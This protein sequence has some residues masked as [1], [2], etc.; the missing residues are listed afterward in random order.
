M[1]ETLAA[2][3]TSYPCTITNNAG[4]DVVVLDAFTTDTTT[5]NPQQM[6]EQTLKLLKNGTDD[7]IKAGATGTVALND[8][9]VDKNGATQPNLIYGFLLA[10][11]GSFF[12]VKAASTAS[13]ASPPSFPPV[14]VAAD[15][16]KNMALGEQFWQTI[17]AYPTSDMA[18]NFT[19][20]VSSA[21]STS[22]TASQVDTSVQNFFKNN[23]KDYTTLT[24]K[25][26]VA[27][28][29]YYNTYP[30]V[31]ADYKGSKTYYLYTSD[32]TTTTY[33]GSVVMNLPAAASTDKSLPDG[34]VMFT[35]ASGAQKKLHFK[36][37]QFVDDVTKDIPAVCLKGLFTLKSTLTK[38]DTDNVIIA[39][40]SGKANGKTV[41]GYPD[42]LAP[43]PTDPNDRWWGLYPLLH[44]KNGQDWLNLLGQVLM[45]YMAY[46]T[47][48]KKTNKTED[49]L[50]N[51]KAENNGRE[52]S[53]AQVDQ[54]R[55]DCNAAQ[56]E[57]NDNCQKLLDKFDAQLKMTD[58]L[59]AQIQDLQQKIEDRFNEEQRTTMEENLH[60]QGDE[61]TDMAQGGV[62]Q[63][64]ENIG[65][66]I[67]TDLNELNVDNTPTSGLTDI[68]PGIQADVMQNDTDL[69]SEMKTA[70]EN[71]TDDIKGEIGRIQDEVKTVED[72]A[73]SI[74]KS[75]GEAREGRT[76][77]DVK[78]DTKIE[79]EL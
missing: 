1:S 63:G 4:V 54:I 45:I 28:Q 16:A 66:T 69:T 65:G 7:A 10:R 32:G 37:G 47:I 20:A 50:A 75:A 53:Q 67:A 58:D 78:Y 52:P 64:M 14:I 43:Q 3:D 17:M 18:K 72:E 11:P 34:A 23:T 39:I 15:D 6:Y 59:N 8:T 25:N 56:K 12:P 21:G 46:E 29:T 9:H 40:L 51:K 5:T 61:L 13:F 49:Q 22:T 33:V 30:F 70:K 55:S 24:L 57:M 38:V 42:K 62:T 31:W 73:N 74:D 36:D 60:K 79:V 48:T 35:D 19:N 26:I 27:V 76:P 41:C 77:E 71:L 44:P 2:T 68:L